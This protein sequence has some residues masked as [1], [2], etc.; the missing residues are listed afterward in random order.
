MCDEISYKFAGN[1]YGYK[2]LSVQNLGLI[3]I[4]K[5]AT[6]A[7]CFENYKGDLNLEMFQLALSNLHKRYMPRKISLIIILA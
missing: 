4:N 5:M 1:V 7:N 3:L 6:I 2:N